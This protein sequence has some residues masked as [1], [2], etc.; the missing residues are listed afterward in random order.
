[1]KKCSFCG[2]LNDNSSQ[3]CNKC[4]ASFNDEKEYVEA[5]VIDKEYNSDEYLKEENRLVNEYQARAKTAF[6]L[7]IISVLLCCCTITSII[8]FILSIILLIDLSKMSND[9][10]NSEEYR[11][12]KNK[13]II[14]LI[15]SSILVIM[16]IIN[17]IDSTL[18]ADKYNQMYNSL[19]NDMMENMPNE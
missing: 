11:K 9:I 10:K 15:I 7:S 3:Y 18:N 12:I 17:A 4:G 14:A 19:M 5:E 2:A 6:N 1:M 8:S 13:A 16:G